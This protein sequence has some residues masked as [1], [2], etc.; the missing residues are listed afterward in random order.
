[1]N[2]YTKASLLFGHEAAAGEADAI[3]AYLAIIGELDEI[4]DVKIIN[5][6]KERI[7]DELNHAL[8]M[9][10]DGIEL[11]GLKISPDNIENVLLRLT[12]AVKYD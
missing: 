6:I 9:I 1:M 7:S 5:N 3:S 12:D 2:K 10:A 8:S 4:T 11:A